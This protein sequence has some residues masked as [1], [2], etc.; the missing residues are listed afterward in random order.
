MLGL[1]ELSLILI[2]TTVANLFVEVGAEIIAEW[3]VN[4]DKA[5][6]VAE[7]AA[8]KLATLDVPGCVAEHAEALRPVAR[9]WVE[10]WAGLAETALKVQM[11]CDGLAV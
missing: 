8:R 10:G 4:G 3:W 11:I 7:G 6:E 2:V 9:L 1:T 5:T